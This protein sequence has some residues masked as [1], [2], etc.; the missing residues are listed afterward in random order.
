MKNINEVSPF[1]SN[2]ISESSTITG[3][4]KV[5]RLAVLVSDEIAASESPGEEELE[6]E[7]EEEF[8]EELILTGRRRSP[9]FLCS[10]PPEF[11]LSSV[12]W[13]WHGQ[14]E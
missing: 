5:D 1:K 2:Y 9:C 4:K 12:L 3:L 6:E 11:N 10:F 13:S 14:I 8:D 7:L